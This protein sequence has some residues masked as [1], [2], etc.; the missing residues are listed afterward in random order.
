MLSPTELLTPPEIDLDELT[1][2]TIAVMGPIEDEDD[3]YSDLEGD[4][5]NEFEDEDD[6]DEDD[7]DKE[8]DEDQ[9]EDNEFDDD[10]D[11]LG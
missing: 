9:D 10:E 6:F 8:D 3:Y 5:E 2:G 4:D 7:E 11:D 1:N